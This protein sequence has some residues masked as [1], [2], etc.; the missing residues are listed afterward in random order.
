MPDKVTEMMNVAV[1][2]PAQALKG[3][4]QPVKH[5]MNF[6][7]LGYPQFW[8]DLVEPGSRLYGDNVQLGDLGENAPRQDYERA[9]ADMIADWNLTDP[10][11]GIALPVPTKEDFSSIYRLPTTFVMQIQREFT[12]LA[13]E[14]T[15]D[16][17]AKKASE[18]SS[19][20]ISE[21]FAAQSPQT[22]T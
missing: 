17:E 5:R 2:K 14:L 16:S 20:A 18:I 10:E 9:M 3:W 7:S 22:G 12:V 15:G 4:L 13:E 21:A 11:T 8:V 1:D 19:G 6:E